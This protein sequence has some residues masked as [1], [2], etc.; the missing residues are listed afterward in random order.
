MRWGRSG[1]LL[2]TVYMTPTRAPI[3]MRAWVMCHSLW[4]EGRGW[5]GCN[6]H[7]N[8]SPTLVSPDR[9]CQ[10]I[11]GHVG[12]ITAGAE[13][14]VMVQRINLLGAPEGLVV[15]KLLSPFGWPILIRP[16]GG[17]PFPATTSSKQAGTKLDI[18]AI[19]I[20]KSE[21][22]SNPGAED[23]TRDQNQKV[24][25]SK[26]PQAAGG[27]VSDSCRTSAKNGRERSP[28]PARGVQLPNG[29]VHAQVRCGQ[30]R[31]QE[32]PLVCEDSSMASGSK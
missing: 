26:S 2:L 11:P 31:H 17:V 30:G 28:Q 23:Q 29:G 7:S 4:E 14:A 5:R 32:R 27:E 18:M 13:V 21:Q 20:L 8:C 10:T 15:P 9:E 19:T 6:T 3:H 24:E 1:N 22:A 16:E 12:T 25:A